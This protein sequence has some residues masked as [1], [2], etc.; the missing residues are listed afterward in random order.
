MIKDC[1]FHQL[2]PPRVTTCGRVLFCTA[3]LACF[4]SVSRECYKNAG[5][6]SLA[7]PCSV[8]FLCCTCCA[9]ISLTAASRAYSI[10]VADWVSSWTFSDRYSSYNFYR[11]LAKLDIHELSTNAQKNCG[12]IFQ[13]FD[14]KIVVK[15]L[16]FCILT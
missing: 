16:K 10:P 1:F 4:E 9:F 12:T 11:I 2:L 14:F 3:S 5:V 13:I 15:F 7:V 6:C 8:D